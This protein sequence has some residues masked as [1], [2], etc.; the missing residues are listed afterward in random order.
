M[1]RIVVLIISLI[2]VFNAFAQNNMR[3]VEELIN[4]ADPGWPLVKQWIDSAKNKV[5]ILPVDTIKSR[6][7]LFQT[8]VTTRSPMGAIIYKTGGILIDGGWIRILGSGH[9]RFNRTLPEWNKGKSFKEYGETPTYLLVADDVM[10]GFFA[11]NGGA[12][13]KEMGK[14]YYFAPDNLEWEEVNK[15]YTE[16]LLFCFNGDLDKFYEGYRWK[17]WQ[18]EVAALPGDKVYSFFP[19][20]YTRE[21]KNI[22]NSTKSAVPVEEQFQ[23]NLTMRK[24]LGLETNFH[25]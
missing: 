1:R 14:V 25:K 6:G 22:N 9:P 11:I 20:L 5:E 10:G 8:Q 12:F 24:Q 3:K 19:Y 21:G 13:G 17:G 15:T 16:F 4:T 23:F 18:K 2:T 7:V